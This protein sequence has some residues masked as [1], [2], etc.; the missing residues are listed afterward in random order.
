MLRILLLRHAQSTWNA[1]RLWQGRADPP[2][3]ELGQLSAKTI[4]PYFEAVDASYCSP[5]LRA[6]QTAE[7]ISQTLG[8]DPPLPN[9]NLVERDLGEWAGLTREEVD[10][11]WP[12]YLAKHRWPPGA[13]T[14]DSVRQRALLGLEQVINSTRA[15]LGETATVLVVTHGGLITTVEQTLGLAWR[16]IV[17]LSGRELLANGDELALGQVLERPRELSQEVLL[18]D[19]PDPEAL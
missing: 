8:F 14:T 12:G 6:T 16:R 13:E 3:S 4:A 10:Q 9:D 19:S 2:L 1:Q 18:A 15:N 17:N 11:G 7:I 5:L